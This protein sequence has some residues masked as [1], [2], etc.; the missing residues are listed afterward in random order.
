M[1]QKWCFASIA[2]PYKFLHGDRIS[3]LFEENKKLKICTEKYKICGRR[4]YKKQ[5]DSFLLGS[6][7]VS[8]ITEM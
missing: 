3:L 6:L 7:F 5:A 1:P 8:K 2:L 4:L